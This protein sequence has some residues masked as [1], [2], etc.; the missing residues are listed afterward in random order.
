MKPFASFIV[1]PC[2]SGFAA[3]TRAADRGE[4]GK[5][6]LPGGKIDKGEDALQ[7]AIREANEEG[8]AVFGVSTT[9]I[10]EA[11]VEGKLVLWFRASF[12]Y[13]LSEY[14]EKGRISPITVSR[15]EIVN[16]G[17]GNEFLKDYSF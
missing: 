13:S 5:V 16:S 9:P 1:T 6:G 10:H 12:A 14:K 4:A 2:G 8:F 3:T 7:G 15:E 11:I 17:Y